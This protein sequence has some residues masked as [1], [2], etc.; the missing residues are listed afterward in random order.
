MTPTSLPRKHREALACI[1][2]WAIA[3]CSAGPSPESRTCASP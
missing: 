2:G 1:G 3:D